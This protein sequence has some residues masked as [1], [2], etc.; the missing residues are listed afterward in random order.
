[1]STHRATIL[2]GLLLA[3]PGFAG[4][5]PVALPVERMLSADAGPRPVPNAVFA[6]SRQDRRPCR[7]PH[8]QAR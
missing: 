1:M 4:F 2:L 6:P 3:A 5:A 8:S 7:H